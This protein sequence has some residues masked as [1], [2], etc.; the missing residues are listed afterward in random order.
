MKEI[1]FLF[2]PFENQK[3]KHFDW[4]FF[5]VSAFKFDNLFHHIAPFISHWKKKRKD[6]WWTFCSSWLVKSLG[7]FNES[8]EITAFTGENLSVRAFSSFV[9]RAYRFFS[10]FKSIKSSICWTLIHL[11]RRNLIPVRGSEESKFEGN[12]GRACWTAQRLL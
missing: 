5:W 2:S 8:W 1:P 10:R 9:W 4:V 6:N 11:S 12:P 3:K 7:H